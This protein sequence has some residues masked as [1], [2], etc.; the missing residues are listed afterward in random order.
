MSSSKFL[1]LF[2]TQN[3]TT[4]NNFYL[5]LVTT[6]LLSFFLLSDVAARPS[7]EKYYLRLAQSKDS[8]K[9]DL[10][11]TSI[12][13][14]AFKE[15]LVGYVDL[16]RLESDI[17]GN[18][19]TL[20]FGGGYVFNWDVSLYLSLGASLGYNKDNSDYL[21]AYYPEVG[22]VADITKKFGI[23]ASTRRYHHLYDENESIVMLGLVF[24]D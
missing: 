14:L 2:S 16:N 23:T 20:D 11:I 12:G 13:I 10:D 15:N 17:N 18:G 7:S 6:A 8:E 5:L 19:L 22:I 4:N 3:K 24:R 21:A 1:T 9:T